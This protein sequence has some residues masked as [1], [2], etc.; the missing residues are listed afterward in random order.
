MG[1]EGV[2][3]RNDAIDNGITVFTPGAAAATPPKGSLPVIIPPPE[4]ECALGVGESSGVGTTNEPGR[5]STNSP[6]PIGIAGPVIV[7][8]MSDAEGGDM[9]DE[10]LDEFAVAATATAD[11]EGTSVNVEGGGEG[12]GAPSLPTAAAAAAATSADESNGSGSWMG[13]PEAG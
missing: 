12:M 1:D 2:G 3:S 10:P 11:G 7:W 9:D 5:F 13:P 8:S 4:P 6:G